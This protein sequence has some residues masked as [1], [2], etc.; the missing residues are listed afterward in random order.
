M[1]CRAALLG[2]LL[3]L[4]LAAPAAA[5][6]TG[7]QSV[8]VLGVPHVIIDSAT[9]AA[10]TSITNPV[11][12]T[13]TFWQAT[14]PVSGTVTANQ[15]G[16][17]TLQPGNTANTTA[18]LVTGTGGTFPVTGTFWQATQPVSGTFW[19]A[20]QPVSGTFWQATQPVSG[21]V[22]ADAGANLNTSA[23]LTTTA[24]DAA[25]GTAG[26]ADAQV[27]TVQ[28]IAGGTA[29]PV[30]GTFWQ[31]T[32][33]VSGTFWQ[34]TQPVSGTFWQT[35]QPVSGT[36]TANPATYAGKTLTYV[37]V[38]QGV[39][40]TTVIAAASV[41]NKHKIVGGL[42]SMSL[43]GTLKFDDGVADVIGPLDTSATGGF[44]ATPSAIPWGETNATNRALNLITTLGA[45]RGVVIVLTEP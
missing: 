4:V 20:T 7:V 15:G 10:I 25:F 23:L 6:L 44:A 1:R 22:T 40:G 38:N 45:A 3:L 37:S 14:Q 12:V 11:A 13:G 8:R 39:A 41:G 24:H 21:T 5:Q 35:T 33:P 26:S 17:W 27:R 28:G 9:I 30:S 18:W 31:A 2:P 36:V 34:A 19:Q 43:L 32:Q 29:V 42:L 16:T